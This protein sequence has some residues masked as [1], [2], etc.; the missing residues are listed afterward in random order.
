MKVLN[1]IIKSAKIVETSRVII[2]S[3]A[4]IWLKRTQ[5]FMSD[6]SDLNPRALDLLIAV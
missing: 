6:S 5:A 1:L 4:Q 3:D 2:L